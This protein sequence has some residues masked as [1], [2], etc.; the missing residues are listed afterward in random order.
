M[1]GE[2]ITHPG[3]RAHAAPTHSPSPASRERGRRSRRG[4]RADRG[5]AHDA[6]EGQFRR[7]SPPLASPAGEGSALAG[8]E[9]LPSSQ[10]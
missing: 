6:G 4:L 7:T 1:C 9:E 2:R 10:G 3:T 8:G 5:V